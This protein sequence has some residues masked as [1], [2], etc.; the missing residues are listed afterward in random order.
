VWANANTGFNG[1]TLILGAATA[2]SMVTV[3]NPLDLGTA[4]RTVQVDDG[5]APVDA[6]LSGVLSG[7]GG[8][9]KTGAGTL[10]LTGTNTY[11]GDTTVSGGTLAI[12]QATLA[13]NS[14][15]TVAGGAVLELDFAG[16]NTVSK[17]VLNGA[18]Q[19]PGVYNSTTAA[20]YITGPGSLVLSPTLSPPTISSFGPL[21][22]TS[23]PLTFSGPSGQSYQ[24]L[25]STNVALPL[26]NWTALTSGT[27]GASPVTYTD[28][29]ATNKQQFYRIQSP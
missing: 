26:T 1:Q 9:I 13:A 5:A 11:T 2:Y 20:P 8:L 7:S 16:T 21:T 10:S 4:M 28:T 17:L 24:V 3:Q 27:F 23:F 19:V 22:G 29:S 15:V 14:T 12:W 6:T 25:T 18:S